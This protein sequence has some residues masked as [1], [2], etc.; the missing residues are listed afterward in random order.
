MCL[1]FGKSWQKINLNTNLGLNYIILESNSGLELKN[2]GTSYN[3]SLSVRY[4]VCENGTFSVFGGLFS[5]RIMLQGKS[6]TYSYSSISYSQQLLK[7]KLMIN[8]LVT[9]PFRERLIYK[10]HSATRLYT[11]NRKL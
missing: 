4:N 2:E 10:P 11:D 5:P 6:S 3:G 8:I 7:K 1:R 9:D